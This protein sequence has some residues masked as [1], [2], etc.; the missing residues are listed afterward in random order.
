M[1]ATSSYRLLL[2]LLKSLPPDEYLWIQKPRFSPAEE[3][4]R[5]PDFIIVHLGRGGVVAL[6][7]KEWAQVAQLDANHAILPDENG[8]FIAEANPVLIAQSTAG[9]VSRRFKKLNQ[10]LHRH[11]RIQW[12]RLPWIGAVALPNLSV[13][14]L[15]QCEAAG[16]WLPGQ[17]LTAADLTPECFLTALDRLPWPSRPPEAMDAAAVDL[18]RAAVNPRLLIRDGK[19]KLTGVLTMAQDELIHK[20]LPKEGQAR[21][22][23]LLPDDFLSKEAIEAIE[24]LSVQLVRGVAGSGKTLVLARRAHYLAREYPKLNVLVLTSNRDLVADLRRR[25]PKTKR[26]TVLSF[27]KLCKRILGAAWT[28]PFD[29]AAWLGRSYLDLLEQH[30]LTAEFLADEILWRKHIGL[31]DNHKY[32]TIARSG[33]GSRLGKDKRQIVNQ[34]FDAYAEHH[35]QRDLVDKADIAYLALAALEKQG[36]QAIHFDSILLDEAHDFPPAWVQVILKVLNPKGSLFM[37]DDPTQSQYPSYSWQQKGVNVAGRTRVLRV[38]FRCTVEITTAAY[39][40]LLVDRKLREWEAMTIP[41]LNSYEMN[42][43]GK[44][45]LAGCRNAAHEIAYIYESVRLALRLGVKPEDIA[46]LCHDKQMVK[47]FVELNLEDNVNVL[48]FDRM[49]GLEFKTVYIP[50]LGA[51]FNRASGDDE[52]SRDLRRTLFT[53]MTRAR[54]FLG[55]SYHGALPPELQ[56]LEPYVQAAQPG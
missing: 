36:E 25:V 3:P 39:S 48:P 52:A 41:D 43:G 16:A 33:R 32:L 9:D 54:V 10:D 51:Y 50:G 40:L 11:K 55:L 35:A 20:P 13:D 18:I 8:K 24:T 34:L 5:N 44:P 19:G 14:F 28:K 30:R 53:A 2:H 21:P 27:N 42:S 31:T 15:R 4:I 22:R 49:K 17:A 7:L 6:D 1:A 47:E 12:G 29:L 23:P 38:P 46:I 37:C 26:M 56:P 45:L